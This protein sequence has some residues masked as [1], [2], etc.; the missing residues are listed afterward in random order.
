MKRYAGGEPVQGG[1]YVDV[2]TGQL[3]SFGRK[4]DAVLPGTVSTRYARVPVGFVLVLGPLAGLAYIIFLPLAGIGSLVILAG[5]K[6]RAWSA[7][8][9]PKPVK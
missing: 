1:V 3:V 2:K 8:L 9:M 5:Y 6:V 4:E 7:T